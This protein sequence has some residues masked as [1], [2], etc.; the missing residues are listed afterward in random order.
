MKRRGFTLIELLVVIAIIAILAAILF[1]VFAKAREKARQSSCSSNLKQIGIAWSSYTQDYD[2]TVSPFTDS[3]SSGGYT[4]NW[5]ETLQPYVKSIQVMKCPS[6]AQKAC[7]YTYNAEMARTNPNNGTPRTLAGISLTTAAP[8]FIDALG[9][10][11][12]FNQACY[13]FV[14]RPG[15][16]SSG[17]SLKTSV[18]GTNNVNNPDDA[19]KINP[20]VH[21]DGANYQFVDG[22]VKWYKFAN[23]PGN[24]ADTN[25]YPARIGIDYVG[26]GLVGTATQLGLWQ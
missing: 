25:V 19:A 8:I 24:A 9:T 5:M 3:G 17:R 18:M 23:N 16:N 10:T 20:N 22:H 15:I 14:D 13:F 2:E 1:P 26:T 4:F 21:T 7:S 11:G 6:N 12:N